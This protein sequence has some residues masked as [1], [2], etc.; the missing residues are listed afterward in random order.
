LLDTKNTEL[1]E[2]HSSSPDVRVFS[3][4]WNTRT[5]AGNAFAET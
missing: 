5:L 1:L 3:S 4:G 2:V